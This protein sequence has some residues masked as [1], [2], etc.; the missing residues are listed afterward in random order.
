MDVERASMVL[1][2]EMLQNGAELTRLPRWLHDAIDNVNAVT[3][4]CPH[5]A[6][7]TGDVALPL[8]LR[9]HDGMVT[10]A[11]CP[12]PPCRVCDACGSPATYQGAAAMDVVMVLISVC[13]V[14][15]DELSR[16]SL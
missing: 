1:E 9:L 8:W 13:D 6:A 7:P 4:G 16:N 15:A 2:A 3:L 12:A 10:C 5:V 14:H 11:E